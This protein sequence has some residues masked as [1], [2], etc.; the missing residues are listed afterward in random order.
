MKLYAT[1]YDGTVSHGGV[2][3]GLL[4]ALAAWRRAG[5]RFGIVT[6]R[7]FASMLSELHR[8]RLPVDFLIADNGSTVCS[9]DGKVLM[10]TWVDGRDAVTAL[11]VSAG[12]GCCVSRM[13]NTD[14]YLMMAAPPE[15]IAALPGGE[16][17][18]LGMTVMRH[19]SEI[20]VVF[21]S[22]DKRVAAREAVEKATEGRLHGLSSGPYVNDFVASDTDKAE[23]IRRYIRIAGIRPG[24]IYTTGDALNDLAMINDPE[25]EGY[26]VE[27]GMEEVKAVSKVIKSPLELL[28]SAL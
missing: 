2:T 20:C 10:S 22:S 15:D 25:F 19:V 1:D 24:K 23:G 26:C 5:N 11:N 14:G 4:E 27:N 21:D 12:F 28:R 13:S 17:V 18:A 9:G 8:V 6:G 7:P 16:G 3:P